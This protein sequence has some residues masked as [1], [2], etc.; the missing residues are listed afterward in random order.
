MSGALF[1][2]CGE[3][4]CSLDGFTAIVTWCPIRYH[5][6]K[7]D[8]V[9]NYLF[10]DFSPG[11]EKG[12]VMDIELHEKIDQCLHDESRSNPRLKWAPL[13]LQQVKWRLSRYC[14][15]KECLRKMMREFNSTSVTISSDKD[16][17]MVA[18]TVAV[19]KEM[20]IL[21]KIGNGVLDQTTTNIL[22]RQAPYG[23][24]RAYDPWWF[25][26]LRWRISSL[27]RPQKVFIETYGN[28]TKL[29]KNFLVFRLARSIGFLSALKKKLRRILHIP[30]PET[31]VDLDNT[32]D[33]GV[34]MLI[35]DSI[36]SLFSSD[37]RVLI[38]HILTRFFD[39]YK[40][41]IL[42]RVVERVRYIFK[43][44]KPKCYV[45]ATDQNDLNRFLYA[46]AKQEGV[47]TAYLPHGVVWESYLGKKRL[48]SPFQPDRVLAWSCSSEEEFE[49]IKW[50][51]LTIRHP[52]FQN[53]SQPLRPLSSNR[54]QWKV[55]VF[56]PEWYGV[57]LAGR[58]DCA[59][60]DFIEIYNGLRTAG[61]AGE[62][63]LVS[64]HHSSIKAVMDAKHQGFQRLQDEL[65]M[66]F[67][68]HTVEA[69]KQDRFFGC[70]LVIMGATTGILEAVASG[71]PII[72]F[73]MG[74]DRLGVLKSIGLPHAYNREEIQQCIRTYNEDDARDAYKKL[75]RSL[76]EGVSL[77]E[78]I[79]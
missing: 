43:V 54:A 71:I 3:V 50:P 35:Q 53:K 36:W 16:V 29:P 11:N 76:Q 4:D 69:Y 10:S 9:E 37:E 78:I 65:E 42:D 61:V 48:D 70:D 34:P 25:F 8:G 67:K 22:Y 1:I 44:M 45:G 74:I 6:L 21:C 17:E 73:G 55:F 72:T 14:W 79:A 39:R 46:A 2:L 26:A 27:S 20:N 32:M 15:L 58:E 66:E 52:Q 63:I 28:L 24:P 68:L 40:A 41:R 56:I 64:F 60:V 19:A 30:Q 18:A 23:I 12:K 47:D 33:T 51:S 49:K 57:S 75:T 62:N 13:A 77:Q 7:R 5:G 38:N 31:L 59:I